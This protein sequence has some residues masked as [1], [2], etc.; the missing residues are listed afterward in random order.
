MNQLNELTSQ[1]RKLFSISDRLDADREF[2]LWDDEVGE[3][4]AERFPDSRLSAKWSSLGSSNLV[5]DHWCPVKIF[6]KQNNYMI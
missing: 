6:L 1:G 2:K 5:W 3:W 4:L